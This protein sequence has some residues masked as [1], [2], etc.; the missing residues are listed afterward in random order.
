MLQTVT[1][2]YI[3]CG[4][5]AFEA[6]LESHQI[7]AARGT[8]ELREIKKDIRKVELMRESWNS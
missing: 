8:T 2:F 1:L 4:R 7:L 5:T 6:M 3:H